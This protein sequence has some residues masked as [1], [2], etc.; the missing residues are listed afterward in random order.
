[1]KKGFLDN[2]ACAGERWDASEATTGRDRRH[3]GRIYGPIFV[4]LGQQVREPTYSDFRV[5]PNF[6]AMGV[7]AFVFSKSLCEM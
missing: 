7:P 4:S 5:V 6:P 2:L 3:D 1:M